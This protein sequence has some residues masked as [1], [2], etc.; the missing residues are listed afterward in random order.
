[1]HRIANIANYVNYSLLSGAVDSN[2]AVEFAQSQAWQQSSAMRIQL[3]AMR[4][5]RAGGYHWTA[6]VC[7]C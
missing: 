7:Q 1:M 4:G 3:V 6:S 5:P 2:D